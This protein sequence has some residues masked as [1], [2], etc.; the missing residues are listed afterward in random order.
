MTPK[1]R[2]QDAIETTVLEAKLL[3]EKIPESAP[4]FTATVED[5]VGWDAMPCLVF[6]QLNRLYFPGCVV[7]VMRME[8]DSKAVLHSITSL[9]MMAIGHGVRVEFRCDTDPKTFETLRRCLCLLFRQSDVPGYAKTYDE[10]SK[11]LLAFESRGPELLL[12]ELTRLV[13]LGNRNPLLRQEATIT[14]SLP[15]NEP[16]TAHASCQAAP[17]SSLP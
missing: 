17:A 2:N 15:A 14:D 5:P 4:S 16:A 13:R 6:T 12:E 11:L 3:Y 7:G 9:M 1:N 8:S 10:C